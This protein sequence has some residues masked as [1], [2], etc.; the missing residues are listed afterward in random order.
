[1]NLS[2]YQCEPTAE[3]KAFQYHLIRHYLMRNNKYL[4]LSQVSNITNGSSEHLMTVKNV[5]NF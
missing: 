2:S 1:M 5:D 4:G 3:I